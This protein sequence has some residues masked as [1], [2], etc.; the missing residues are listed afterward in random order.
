MRLPFKEAKA[1][2]A[3]AHLL[4]LRGGRMKYLKLVKLLYLADREALLRWGQPLTTD[5]YVSMEYG[6]VVS[7]TYA[8]I[9]NEPQPGAP[10]FWRDHIATVEDWDVQLVHDPSDDELSLAEESLLNEIFEKHGHKN[11][12]RIVD[13]THKFP[14]WKDPNGSSIPIEYSEI[15]RAGQK[16]E[17]E[18]NEIIE[19][20]DSL[21]EAEM[22]LHPAA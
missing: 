12:W 15:L 19:G 10:S 14:E 9:S 18:I 7:R 13:E 4:K 16:S 11:R 8:L 20:L 6:P 3:A 17:A 2:Q 1:T 22:I 21:A 5:H